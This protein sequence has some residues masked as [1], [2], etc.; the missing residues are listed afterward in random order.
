MSIPQPRYYEGTVDFE[1]LSLN[2]Y[3][4]KLSYKPIVAGNVVSKDYSVAGGKFREYK[5]TPYKTPEEVFIHIMGWVDCMLLFISS[6]EIPNDNEDSYKKKYEELL[7][8][9]E[10][11]R[12]EEDI[13]KSQT[14]KEDRELAYQEGWKSK[15]EELNNMEVINPK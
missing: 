10:N 7:D 8:T 9:L 5:T 2:S 4:G 11:K 14:S 13:N 1:P 12:L 15:S 6:G 3:C